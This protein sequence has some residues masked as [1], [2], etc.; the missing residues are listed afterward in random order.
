MLVII[1]IVNF[2]RDILNTN[3]IAH[4][5]KIDRQPQPLQIHLMETAVIA[6]ALLKNLN[7]K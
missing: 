2:G 3:Y 1:G 7:L 4:I 5:R 6:K